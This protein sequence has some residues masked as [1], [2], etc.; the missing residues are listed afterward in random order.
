MTVADALRGA[1]GVKPDTYLGEVLVSRLQPDRTRIQL[2]ARL[3]DTTGAVVN[4]FPLQENDQIRVFSLATFRPARYVAISGFVRK[5]GRYPYRRGMTVRD[6]VLLA[7]GVKE[8]ARLTDAE[9]ARLPEDRSNGQSAVTIRVPLDSTYLFGRARD[10]SYEGPPGTQ[11]SSSGAPEVP[12]EPYDNVLIFRQENFEYQRNVTLRGEV[13]FPGTYALKNKR[14][15]LRDVIMRAGGLT[16]EA[17]ADGIV[18]VRNPDRLVHDGRALLPDTTVRDSLARDSLLTDSLTLIQVMRGRVGLDLA[19]A[20]RKPDSPD[21]LVLED[22]D[23]ILIPRFNAV[24]RVQGAVNAPSNVTYIPGR[25]LNYYV[26]AAGGA[27]RTGDK[28]RAYVTQPSGRL[29]SVHA[30]PLLPDG[31]PVPRPGAVVTVPEKPTS[32][33]SDWVGLA[34]VFAQVVA[35]LATIVV[36]SRR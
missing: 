22:G 5:P 36:I 27:S 29:Q 17:Q 4:D 31:V 30:R 28:S 25:D 12:L 14:E 26:D 6:L 8:G 23:Q 24:V 11:V 20:M 34:T 9:I 15:R 21:N 2:R 32:D 18:F 1:G 10:G 16:D 35:S 13:K 7:D 19:V 33:K 3:A